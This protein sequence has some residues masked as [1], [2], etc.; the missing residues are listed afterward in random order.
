[1]KQLI[2]LHYNRNPKL[3]KKKSTKDYKNWNH[4][5]LKKMLEPGK[6]GGKLELAETDAIRSAYWKGVNIFRF[7][8]KIIIF[9]SYFTYFCLNWNLSFAAD[10][11]V[12]AD[13]WCCWNP[14]Q[15]FGTFSW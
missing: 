1:M 6:N 10:S 4:K 2:L 11:C 3:E 9:F 13:G 15:S 12:P 8:E 7:S 14:L 5:S